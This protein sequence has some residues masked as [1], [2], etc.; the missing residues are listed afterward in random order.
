MGDKTCLRIAQQAAQPGTASYGQSPIH[1]L[2]ARDK[3]ASPVGASHFL[4]KLLNSHAPRHLHQPLQSPVDPLAMADH[5]HHST[6]GLVVYS[7][8]NV[9]FPLVHPIVG[10]VIVCAPA[11][12][13][14]SGLALKGEELQDHSLELLRC[15]S[16]DVF[17]A[18]WYTLSLYIN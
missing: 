8:E 10:V 13:V 9:V 15:T 7:V 2:E 6:L 17:A 1:R 3:S 18:F 5:E 14:R 16:L 11:A 12:V 4:D